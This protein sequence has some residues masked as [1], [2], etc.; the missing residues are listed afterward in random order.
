MVAGERILLIG[1][2][3]AAV[4]DVAVVAAAGGGGGDGGG[5]VVVV[6]PFLVGLVAQYVLG[7]SPVSMKLWNYST[8]LLL[9]VSD[10]LPSLLETNLTDAKSGFLLY[11]I[12]V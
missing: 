2:W 1:M 11:V 6:V 3:S 12:H 7:L 8:T 5:G 9:P 4:A 10:V